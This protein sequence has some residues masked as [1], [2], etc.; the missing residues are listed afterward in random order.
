MKKKRRLVAN[1]VHSKLL[2]AAPVWANALQNHAFQKRLFSGQRSAAL[3]IVSAYRTVSMSAVLV[4]ASV[5]PIDLFVEERQET[6]QLHKKLTCTDLQG[7]TSAKEAIR[8]DG[9]HRL[10]EKWQMS[11]HGEQAGRWAYRLIPDLATWLN[12]K[13]G[14]VSFCL[15]QALSGH[16]CYNAYLKRFKKGD[17]EMCYYCNSP[18]DNAEHALFVC[19]K[20]GAAREAI[21][22]AVGAEL[23]SDTMVSLMLQS[24]RFWTLTESFVT[25][26]MR[27]RELDGRRE[28][29]NA[30]GQ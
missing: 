18:V 12:R 25:L 2:Y 3:T 1:V 8:K 15:A 9:R 21:S 30:E 26:V 16:G 10:V 17:E 4:L 28:R 14:E 22:Q 5:P 29:N 23:T 20:W 11:W 13:H 24:E 27:T 7:I 19:A 6:F